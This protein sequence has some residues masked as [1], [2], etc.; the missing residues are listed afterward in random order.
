MYLGASH[1]SHTLENSLASDL[2]PNFVLLHEFELLPALLVLLQLQRLLVAIVRLRVVGGAMEVKS[3][4]EG[5]AGATRLMPE[6][7][8]G[9]VHLPVGGADGARGGQAGVK[10]ATGR[11]LR[12][13]R[14]LL[15]Q[16]LLPPPAPHC[17]ARGVRMTRSL[18]RPQNHSPRE[19]GGLLEVAR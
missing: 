4:G 1:L 3:R 11:T 12:L 2:L 5:A 17:I 8:P 7:A 15:Q 16:A 19:T 9:R 6:G 13:P 10:G 18:V 14:A